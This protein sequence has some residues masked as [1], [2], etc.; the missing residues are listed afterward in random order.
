MKAAKKSRAVSPA[1]PCTVTLPAEAVARIDE[2]R[3][4]QPP[5]ALIEKL[6]EAEWERRQRA[7]FIKTVEREY[8][9]EVRESTLRINEAFPTHEG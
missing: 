1:P 4:N 6:I 9:P 5:A 7:L 3:G 8:T 2:L